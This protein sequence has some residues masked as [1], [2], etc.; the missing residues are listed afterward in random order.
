MVIL[1]FISR[2]Y[3]PKNCAICYSNGCK[4]HK[5]YFAYSYNAKVCVACSAKYK[6]TSDIVGWLE[7]HAEYNNGLIIG[8]KKEESQ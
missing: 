7:T 5:F 6:S 3:N 1:T 2:D 4:K 8:F